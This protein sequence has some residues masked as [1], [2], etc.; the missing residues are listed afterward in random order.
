[1]T[2]VLGGFGIAAVGVHVAAEAPPSG[3]V[4]L[5]DAKRIAGGKLALFGNLMGQA[6]FSLALGS[7][8]HGRSTRAATKWST[9]RKWP[10][11]VSGWLGA[12]K[13]KG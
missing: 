10:W 7:S 11:Y 3:D 5:A 4:E 13:L 2:V 12:V 1:M 6:A 8:F 9:F